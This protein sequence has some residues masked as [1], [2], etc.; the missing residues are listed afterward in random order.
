ML[1]GKKSWTYFHHKGTNTTLSD[2]VHRVI[3]KKKDVDLSMLCVQLVFSP[4]KIIY[5]S[6]TH[7][8]ALCIVR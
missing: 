1:K 6:F 4:Q 7:V 3:V 8:F 2:K 5:C